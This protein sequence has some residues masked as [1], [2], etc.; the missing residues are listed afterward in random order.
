ME[1][2]G[3]PEDLSFEFTGMVFYG[4]V[5]GDRSYDFGGTGSWGANALSVYN[6]GIFSLEDDRWVL[7]GNFD[8]VVYDP[9]FTTEDCT[10]TGPVKAYQISD[11]EAL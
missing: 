1:I 6:E 2:A 8:V 5:S 10:I 7:D 4:S 3:D 11:R 9:E